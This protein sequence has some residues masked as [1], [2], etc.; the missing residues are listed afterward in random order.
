MPNKYNAL[1]IAIL[2]ISFTKI[3]NAVAIDS[4][5]SILS[6]KCLYTFSKQDEKTEV[7]VKEKSET[8]YKNILA[9]VL[10]IT[11]FYNEKSKIISLNCRLNNKSVRNFSPV[12]TYYTVKDVFYSDVRMNYFPLEV[13]SNSITDISLEKIT[14]DAK[15]FTS[16]YFTEEY[17]TLSK[18]II[19]KIPRWMDIDLKEMNFEG[20]NIT[21]TITYNEKDNEDIIKYT[22]LNLPAMTAEALSPGQSYIYPHLLFLAKDKSTSSV[23]FNSLQDQYNWYR[24][25]TKD[26]NDEKEPAIQQQAQE[27]TAN[28][29]TELEKVSA[30][31]YWVQNNIRY[32]AFEDG[33][34]GFKPDSA[35]EVLRKKYGDCKGMANLTKTLLKVL[36]IDARLSWL[37]TNHIAYNYSTP[38]LAVD[39]HMI[40]TVFLNGKL[41][42]L[43]TTESF[44]GFNE[45]AERIQG[46]EVLIEDNDKYSLTKVPLSNEN[47]NLDFVKKSL[48]IDGINLLGTATHIWKGEDKEVLLSN[49]HS[50]KKEKLYATLSEY[51]G[52]KNQNYEIQ[53]LKLPALDVYD[54]DIS[55][56]YNLKFKNGVDLFDKV[57]YVTLDQ[58]KEYDNFKIDQGE[59]NHEIWL[60]Y[61]VNIQKEI[62]LNI[63]ANYELKDKPSNLA[64]KTS[65]YEFNISYEVLSDKIIYKK[66]IKIPNPKITKTAFTQWNDDIKKLT[67]IYSETITLKPKS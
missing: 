24:S 37:G 53:D 18:E 17:R 11:A 21:K 7:T 23:Y 45:Y 59:R 41:Y 43:D 27:I 38:S 54:K 65:S 3:A 1:I 4:N 48:N 62:I 14:Y 6:A 52:N 49:I 15:Y 33:I 35:A 39:N 57:Y 61:K 36:G 16:V 13:P 32:I 47:S 55:V 58:D 31:Y 56:S 51:L 9:Q 25:L 66:L 28:C 60:P 50:S 67:Q 29:K 44:L 63:P 22:C 42:F 8:R 46:R 64:I 30:V 20:F 19:V 40:C 10:P 5:I 12:D 2:C 34:A 26:L